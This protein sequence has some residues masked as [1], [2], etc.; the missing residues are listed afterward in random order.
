MVFLFWEESEK[1]E[2]LGVVVVSCGFAD[3]LET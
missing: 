2:I 1:E 3:I